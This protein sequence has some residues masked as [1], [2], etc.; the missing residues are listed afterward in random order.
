M[1]SKVSAGLY[2][3]SQDLEASRGG[4]SEA[5]MMRG[6]GLGKMPTGPPALQGVSRPDTKNPRL[7]GRRGF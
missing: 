2:P 1:N 7:T 5:E 4:E 6:R 3:W